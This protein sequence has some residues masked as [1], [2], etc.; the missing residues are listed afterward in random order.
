MSVR[1]NIDKLLIVLN[2]TLFLTKQIWVWE[3][4]LDFIEETFTCYHVKPPQ[5]QDFVFANIKS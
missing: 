1:K 3:T 4:N 2:M 5:I